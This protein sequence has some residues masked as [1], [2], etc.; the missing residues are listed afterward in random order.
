MA[1]RDRMLDDV[2][3]A[4]NTVAKLLRSCAPED[5]A[6]IMQAVDVYARLSAL[7]AQ[8]DAH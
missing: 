1:E 6:D 2:G 3:A 5:Y 7:A 4:R 8:M